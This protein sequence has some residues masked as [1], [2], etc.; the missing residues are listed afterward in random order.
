MKKGSK[1]AIIGCMKRTFSV[2]GTK[3]L[4]YGYKEVRSVAHY[5]LNIQLWDAISLEPISVLQGYLWGNDEDIEVLLSP[6]GNFLVGAEA[7]SRSI[8]L[9][10]TSDAKLLDTFQRKE[11]SGMPGM[12]LNFIDS[13]TLMI[14]SR[15]YLEF[16]HIDEDDAKLKHTIIPESPLNLNSSIEAI[17]N[18]ISNQLVSYLYHP[19][20]LTSPS[21]EQIEE[22]YELKLWS[23]KSFEP[24]LTINLNELQDIE[25]L[26][27]EV[28]FNVDGTQL[29]ILVSNYGGG[30][31]VKETV[32]VWSLEDNN[33]LDTL[34]N[35]PAN[36]PKKVKPEVKDSQGCVI[37]P[38]I[39]N[40]VIV[41]FPT[42][43]PS[44]S[45]QSKCQQ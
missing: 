32:Y 30:A 26:V 44:L 33:L 19:T 25:G 23:I 15:N 41:T 11:S 39:K 17:Y 18:P 1:W 42:Y 40:G 31:Q 6:D 13:S 35:F 7:A 37:R 22:L 20:A 24:V 28:R 10:R 27:Q 38:Q 36:F 45:S 16:W 43:S 29:A 12:D 8:Y 9:W 2:D 14:N 3:L 5:D 4:A 21:K 34:D